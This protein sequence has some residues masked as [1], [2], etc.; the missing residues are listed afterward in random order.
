MD[1]K[2]RD[3]FQKFISFLMCV[4]ACVHAYDTQMSDCPNV[5]FRR[6]SMMMM[7]MMEMTMITIRGRNFHRSVSM[8]IFVQ[9]NRS[10]VGFY[11]SVIVASCF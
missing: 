4:H 6:C 5:V 8:L 7:M 9:M 10:V 11:F 1:H 3:I 2:S